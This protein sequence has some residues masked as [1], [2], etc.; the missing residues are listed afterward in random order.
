MT[1]THAL[2]T[3]GQFLG[4]DNVTLNGVPEPTSMSLILLGGAG[5]ILGRRRQR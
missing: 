3:G 1:P 5:L 4:L 2:A